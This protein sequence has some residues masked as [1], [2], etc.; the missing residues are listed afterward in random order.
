MIS[1]IHGLPWEKAFDKEVRMSLT[2]HRE[3]QID[4][5]KKTLCLETQL[6]VCQPITLSR[7]LQALHQD[8]WLASTSLDS[9]ELKNNQIIIDFYLEGNE[10]GEGYDS[11]RLNWKLLK[12][13]GSTATLEDQ[14]E[15]T[16]LT[17]NKIFL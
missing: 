1:K 16:I 5:L 13:D 12:E 4:L 14:S 2:Y 15:E 17:L 7:V 10:F 3:S 8:K 11:F 6:I 9:V